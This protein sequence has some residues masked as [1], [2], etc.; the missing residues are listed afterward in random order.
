MQTASSS[1]VSPTASAGAGRPASLTLSLTMQ[2]SQF[3]C[4]RRREEGTEDGEMPGE[5]GSP[6]VGLSQ[7]LKTLVQ[8]PTH[9]T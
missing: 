9:F 1:W 2:A 7:G 8:G 4:S 5:A 6:S 3:A